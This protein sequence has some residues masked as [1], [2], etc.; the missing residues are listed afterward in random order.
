V[1]DEQLEALVGKLDQRAKLNRAIPLDA[2][3]AH[4]MRAHFER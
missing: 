4:R 3:L 1:T 2:R